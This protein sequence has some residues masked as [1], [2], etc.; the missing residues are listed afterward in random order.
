MF[1]IVS[2]LSI[3]CCFLFFFIFLSF[4]SSFLCLL[5][6]QRLT[7]LIFSIFNIDWSTYLVICKCVECICEY[8]VY[9][10]SVRYSKPICILYILTFCSWKFYKQMY[11]NSVSNWIPY[12]PFQVIS[13]SFVLFYVYFSFL[14]FNRYVFVIVIS[15]I[16]IVVAKFLL[17]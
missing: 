2:H 14:R 1:S 10:L 13:Y 16:C 7:S 15:L 6:Y 17:I 4:T 9:S 12:L 11:S 5:L 3:C 8:V